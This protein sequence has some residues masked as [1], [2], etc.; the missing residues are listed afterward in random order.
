MAM[1]HACVV[2]CILASLHAEAQFLPVSSSRNASPV[3]D[4]D[5]F[6][7]FETIFQQLLKQKLRRIAP[8]E[9]IPAFDVE[10]KPVTTTRSPPKNTWDCS[11]PRIECP[12]GTECVAMGSL[13]SQQTNLCPRDLSCPCICKRGCRFGNQFLSSGLEVLNKKNCRLCHEDG[14]IEFGTKKKKCKEMKKRASKV[15]LLRF[16]P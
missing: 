2:S 9:P 13:R 3:S 16:T 6:N 5:I 8:G 14:R 1:L 12:R 11:D 15:T 10:I 4:R 7:S